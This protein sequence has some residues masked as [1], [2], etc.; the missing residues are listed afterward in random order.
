MA[1]NDKMRERLNQIMELNDQIKTL[2]KKLELLLS[3]EK[4]VVL[5]PDFSINAEVLTVLKEAGSE[6]MAKKRIQ[7]VL[8]EKFPNYGIDKRKVA[9]ALA[10]LK[11]S[12]GKIES[13]GRA[14]YKAT[15]VS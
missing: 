4:E 5:P 13:I 10:Y 6:G 15:D 2:E 14:V 1:I 12:K 7:K 3:P 11:N 9:S 8:Q